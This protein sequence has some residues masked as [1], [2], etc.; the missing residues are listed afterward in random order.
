MPYQHPDHETNGDG[1]E[2]SEDANMVEGESFIDVQLR[3]VLYL[4]LVVLSK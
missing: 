4:T 1:A 3:C 2:V